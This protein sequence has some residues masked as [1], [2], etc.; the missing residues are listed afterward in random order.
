MQI[1]EEKQQLSFHLQQ[2]RLIELI[3]QGKTEDALEFAQEYLAPRGEENPALLEELGKLLVMAFLLVT[4]RKLLAIICFHLPLSI[5]FASLFI[6]L[7]CLMVRLSVG[8]L[9]SE[10]WPFW[11]LKTL[12]AA[13]SLT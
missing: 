2:Q 8:R 12:A 6:L 11:H 10:R 1:L 13:L 4:P 9:Q 5:H 7:M 3:R